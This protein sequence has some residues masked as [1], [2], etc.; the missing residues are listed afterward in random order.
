MKLSIF[1]FTIRIRLYAHIE[2]KGLRILYTVKKKIK[3]FNTKIGKY[4]EQ[5]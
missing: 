2:N 3:H 5:G 1:S 4:F